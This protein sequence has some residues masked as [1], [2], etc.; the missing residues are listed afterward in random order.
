MEHLAR[1]PQRRTKTEYYQFQPSSRLKRSNVMQKKEF[2]SKNQTDSFDFAHQFSEGMQ[3]TNLNEKELLQGLNE[4]FAG[5]T[6]KVR[7][8][9][10]QNKILESEIEQLRQ[11]K[12]A[13]L[14]Q[15][16]DPE[17][18]DLRKLVHEITL[19][20]RKI[21][22]EHR[23]LQQDLYILREKC[24]AEARH[25]SDAESSIM[26]LKKDINDA[27]LSKLQL[28]KKVQSL[29][30]EIVFLKKNHQEEVSEMMAQLR[31][32]Q[33]ST[34]EMKDFGKADITAALRDIRKQLEGHASSNV[35]QTE[36]CFRARVAK[37]T[38]A[39]EMNREALQA[40]KQEIHEQRRQLQYKSIELETVKGTKEALESQLNALE[41]RHDAEISHYQ[42]TIGRLEHE[43]KRTKCEISGHLREYQDLLNVKM[44]LDVEIASYRKLLEGEETRLSSISGTHISLPYV[45]R[46]SPIY[47]LPCFAKHRGT[48]TKTE[49][50]YKFVE[51]IITETTR[52]VEMTEIEETESEEIS[53]GGESTGTERE[54]G[55]EEE[56]VQ[57]T[58]GA[59]VAAEE[60]DIPTVEEEQEKTAETADME[61]PSKDTEEVEDRKPI[62]G[63]R[64]F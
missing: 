23:H 14:S 59:E 61:R 30:E 28:D 57:A 33:V 27:Y 32:A 43:L 51:E 26:T 25:R 53:G 56:K 3:P 10:T 9:E 6:E 2:E 18:K 44:A 8:L 11:K 62:E 34:V 50:Q 15:V 63:E 60:E 12:A 19:Q 52:E 13:S 22:V 24:E 7:L 35:Q 36:E 41:E 4:R 54:S 1:S 48:T 47:T 45:Y 55:E 58:I 38:E 64:H 42:D 21:E 20:K 17:I 5:F 37:L 46:Q 40:T 31:E 29:V 49:P 39:A 16:Y